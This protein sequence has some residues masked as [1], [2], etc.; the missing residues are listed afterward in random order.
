ML[1][2]L[3][4]DTES[5]PTKFSNN[6]SEGMMIKPFS[7]VCLIKGQITRIDQ[8]K[9]VKVAAGTLL[10]VR[11]SPYDLI[12]LTL[13][14]TQETTYTLDAFCDYVHTLLP[15]GTAWNRGAKFMNVS[16]QAGVAD[17]EWIFYWTIGNPLHYETFMYGHEHYKRQYL[18]AVN[19]KTM[20]TVQG[21]TP[22][23]NNTPN[24][25]GDS[26]NWACGVAWNPAVYTVPPNQVNGNAHNMLVSGQGENRTE[27][28]IGQP[29]LLGLKVS[30]GNATHDGVNYTSGAIVGTPGYDNPGATPGNMLFLFNGEC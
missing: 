28:I 24:I 9:K 17:L 25:G 3:S 14:P 1:I 16:G 20:P 13:N 5:D 8:G 27:F 4:S 29:N 19:G 15:N 6:F 22:T 12:Q 21:A 26:G 23:S 10:N 30:F 18:S 7:K 2:K 11:Y